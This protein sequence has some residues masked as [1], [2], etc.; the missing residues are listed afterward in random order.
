MIKYITDTRVLAL[1]SGIL[2]TFA[3]LHVVFPLAWICLIPLFVAIHQKS[4]KEI[5]SAGFMFGTAISVVVCS[6]LFNGVG[7]FTG[8]GFIFG[9]LAFLLFLVIS[10]L[11]WGIFLYILGRIQR[12]FPNLGIMT[13]LTVASAW[14]L[15]E[16]V[17]NIPLEGMPWFGRHFSNA[18]TGNLYAIQPAAFFGEY[19]LTFVVILVNYWVAMLFIQQKWKILPLPIL[20]IIAYLS[21]GFLILQGFEDN[22]ISSSKSFKL[23]IVSEN[24]PPEIKWNDQTGNILVNN[25]LHIN[26]NA[27]SLKPD[28]ILWSESAIPWTYSAND[29]LVNEIL[30]ISKPANITHLIGINTAYR[31]KKLYNSVYCLL[32]DS[33][34]VCH[35]DKCKALD[36][37]EKPLAGIIVPF[38]SENGSSVQEGQDHKPLVTPCG[39]A[40]VMICNESFLPKA[41]AD[42]VSNGAQ[43]IVNPSNDGWFRKTA[44]VRQHFF[45]CRLRAVETRKDIVVNSNNGISG[46]LQ[47]SGRIAMARQ[48]EKSYVQIVTVS[49]NNQVSLYTR[50]PFLWIYLCLVFV[51][52][53]ALY[54]FYFKHLTNRSKSD[55]IQNSYVNINN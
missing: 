3:V 4:I 34:T 35:Y 32:P 1:F 12:I 8:G 55:V 53:F 2:C 30:K 54:R 10:A 45:V 29:D 52:S 15:L 18:L 23:A 24:I 41:A 21:A 5:V 46:L 42:M 25:L 40:G 16:F 37:I 22:R 38:F 39:K 17:L 9:I 20:L 49:P 28:I 26:K 7:I 14:V 19:V 31:G 48:E 11:Y 47:A 50:Y 36:F 6:S 51:L 33:S 27:I 44:I 13:G 43:F